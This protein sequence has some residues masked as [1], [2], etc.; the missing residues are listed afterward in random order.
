M[1]QIN[2]AASAANALVEENYAKS[3]FRRQTT[4]LPPIFAE[5]VATARSILMYEPRPGDI[6]TRKNQNR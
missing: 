6:S 2:K 4:I 5:R 3:K 1:L